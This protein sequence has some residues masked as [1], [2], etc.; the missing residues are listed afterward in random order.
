MRWI[1]A[2]LILLALPLTSLAQTNSD[3][4]NTNE[5]VGMLRTMAALEKK[6]VIANALELSRAEDTQFWPIYNQYSVDKGKINGRLVKL[7][8][9]YAANYDHMTNDLARSLVDE[10]MAIQQDLM[11]LRRKY[12]RK[13]DKALS[14]IKLA[15][16]YQIENKL[17]AVSNVRLA[18]R[19]PLVTN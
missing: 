19:I 1:S 16:F 8:N 18:Q 6:V 13:F 7:I 12:L 11:K 2:F 17:D 9:D 5:T 3:M 10:H 15:R 14:P 4:G